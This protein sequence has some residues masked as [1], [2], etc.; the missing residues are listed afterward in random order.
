MLDLLQVI[1][2]FTV[3]LCLVHESIMLGN[4]ETNWPSA[5]IFV[6]LVFHCVY[7][8]W[9]HVVGIRLELRCNLA[10]LCHLSGLA[11]EQDVVSHGPFVLG[12]RLSDINGQETNFIFELRV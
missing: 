11:V 8:H 10:P 7:R 4:K 5:E 2:M 3:W 9:H 1:R 12:V 6:E